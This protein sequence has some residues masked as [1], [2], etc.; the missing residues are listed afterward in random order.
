MI[1]SNRCTV[2]GIKELQMMWNQTGSIVFVVVSILSC[3]TRI[4]R[5]GIVIPFGSNSSSGLLC[6]YKQKLHNALKFINGQVRLVMHIA[7]WFSDDL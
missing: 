2:I 5:V 7:L 6:N 1:S 3:D 4:Q